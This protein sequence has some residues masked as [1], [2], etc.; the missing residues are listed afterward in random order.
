MFRLY[1]KHLYPSF[2]EWQTD[3]FAPWSFQE[4]VLLSVLSFFESRLLSREEFSL[5]KAL[6]CEI[7]MDSGAFAATSMGFELDPYEVAE[8]HALLKAD[9]IVPLDKIILP[10]DG[11]QT[12]QQKIDETIRNT[13]IL[14]DFK[15]KGSEIIAPLQGH[16]PSLLER[17][18]NSYRELGIRKF[19]LGGLVFQSNLEAALARIRLARTITKGYFL[20]V[21]GR[22]LHPE[23]LKA[24]IATGADSVDGYGY[25]L[26]SVKGLYIYGEKYRPI[27]DLTEA[28]FN[29]CSCS[30]C[31]EVDLSDLQRG[32]SIAQHR[33]IEHNIHSLITLKEQFVRTNSP[34]PTKEQFME[35]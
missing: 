4:S 17:L 16:S 30:V 32:D 14:L 11:E 24:V 19:A 7:F 25:I 5:Q 18:F 8:M 27:M 20:H 9:L 10:E 21:F 23:L 3:P 26:S 22:F 13:E 34:S 29:R 12:I 28:Q 35:D 33:L 1:F 2:S 6:D 31:Q 15:P